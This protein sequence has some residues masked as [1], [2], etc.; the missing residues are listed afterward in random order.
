MKNILKNI[1]GIIFGLLIG[2][3]VN[4]GII[5][6]SNSVVELPEGIDPTNIDSLVKNF[7]LFEPIN[8]LMPFL[9]HALGT[10][11][12]AFI[13]AKIA[14]TSKL[15]VALSI[16]CFFILG[17]IQMAILLP[18]PLWFNIADI[19][20]AYIPMAYLGYRLAK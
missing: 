4:M 16:G 5:M 6:I 3:S 2:G 12:A 13:T 15:L 7:H 9:A 17:G 14:A 1:A 18:A 8:F 10:F 20:F 11:I 19:G